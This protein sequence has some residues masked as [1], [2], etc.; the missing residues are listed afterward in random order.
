MHFSVKVKW[1]SVLTYGFVHLLCYNLQPGLILRLASLRDIPQQQ[2][3]SS[4]PL[5]RRHQQVT[6]L[7]PPA[8]LVPL[9]PLRGG[10][11][12]GERRAVGGK[13]KK[14]RGVKEWSR[15]LLEQR[16]N[17]GGGWAVKSV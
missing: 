2:R 3:V 4:Q 1:F 15:C 13:K 12:K 14:V 9:A 16:G 10:R 5:Q 7:Q 8:L 6:Q 17:G 11:E